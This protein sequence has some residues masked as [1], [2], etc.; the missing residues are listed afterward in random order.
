[1]K[2]SCTEFY[3]NWTKRTDMTGKLSFAPKWS[4]LFIAPIFTNSGNYSTALHEGL[5]YRTLSI[6]EGTCRIYRQNRI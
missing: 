3:P 5:L 6:S 4:M 1:M 2:I